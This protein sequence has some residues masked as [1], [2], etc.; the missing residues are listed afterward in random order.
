MNVRV[1][2]RHMVINSF[3][4]H[5]DVYGNGYNDIIDQQGNWGKV[6]ALAPYHFH[7]VI[8]NSVKDSWYTE[9]LIDAFAT[10]CIPIFYGCSD[11]GKHFNSDGIIQFR[12]LHE[13]SNIIQQLS[14][15]LYNSKLDAVQ[16]NMQIASKQKSDYDYLYNKYYNDFKKMVRKK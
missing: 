6:Y 4:D 15:E 10:G 1:Y 3:K 12:S 9:A 2:V 8:M 5:I 16:E 14:P 13:L 11:I 7:L